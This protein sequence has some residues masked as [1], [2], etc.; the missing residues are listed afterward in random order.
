MK[1][2]DEN[3]N[4]CAK[5]AVSILKDAGF[6]TDNVLIIKDGVEDSDISAKFIK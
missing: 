1:V 4:K 5:T 3:E 2:E 6:N